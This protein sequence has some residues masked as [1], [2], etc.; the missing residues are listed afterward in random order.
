MIW[1]GLAALA[2]VGLFLYWRRAQK[3][4]F[5]LGDRVYKRRKD[6][7]F[8]DAAGEVVQATSAVALSLAAAYE[9]RRRHERNRRS[10]GGSSGYDG[11]SGSSVSGCSDGSSGSDGGGS[12]G[13]DGGGGD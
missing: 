11:S 3:R 2:L 1:I 5:V 13:G 10:S 4:V 12:C 8:V 6:G 9:I 7:T